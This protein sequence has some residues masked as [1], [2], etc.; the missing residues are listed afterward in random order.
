LYLDNLAIRAYER[1]ACRQDDVIIG[2]SDF[3][4][5][6]YQRISP[7]HPRVVSIPFGVDTLKF[8]AVTPSDRAKARARM[9]Y[10]P[11]DFVLVMV[12]YAYAPK[13]LVYRGLGLKGHETLIG[14]WQEF[15]ERHPDSHLLVVGDGFGARS[16]AY[17]NRLEQSLV[18]TARAGSVRWVTGQTKVSE[19]YACADVS[20]SPSLSEN[21]GAAVEASALGI[22]SI[23]SDAGGLPEVVSDREGWVFARGD[24]DGLVAQLE[25]AY[26]TFL[27]GRLGA[28]GRAAREKAVGS[29][30]RTVCA[31]LVADEI[32]RSVRSGRETRSA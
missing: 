31:R 32:E 14:A 10:A 2:G 24:V 16:E 4:L 21:H 17:R 27:E 8:T 15:S 12:A 18:A 6:E 5:K 29:F 30:D 26:E 9:G 1:Y 11:T 20:V 23:V 22:P 25:A 19:Y 28:K 3:T 13:R 7:G